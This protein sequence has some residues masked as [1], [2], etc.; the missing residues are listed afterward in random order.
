MILDELGA[1]RQDANGVF[2]YYIKLNNQIIN[3]L[4]IYIYIK[5]SNLGI[6]KD[7]LC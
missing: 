1:I 2:F 4:M 3:F 6:F 7:L 5:S